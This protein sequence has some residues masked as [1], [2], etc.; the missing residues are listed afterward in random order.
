MTL[1]NIATFNI[2]Y[3]NPKDGVNAWPN[4]REWVRDLMDY[5]DFDVVGVQEALVH[6]L[7]FL[8]EK[9]L[10]FV[11]VGRDDAKRAGEFSAILYDKQRLRAVD[12]GTFWLSETPD[13]P[14]KGW[15][16]QLKR[17]CTW[18]RLQERTS[19]R[20]LYLF[21]TH[22]DHKGAVARER[23]AGVILEKIA[24][25]AGKSAPVVLTGDFNAVPDSPP[26]RRVAAVLRNARE[27]TESRPYGPHGTFQGFDTTRALEAPIDYIFVNARLRVLKFATLPDNWGQRYPSDHLPLVAKVEI[28]P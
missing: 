14:S 20:E 8:T 21:N 16:A 25:L 26:V 18:A 7:E 22:F 1:L 17:V 24:A 11:G 23:S 9:R 19:G 27:A 4:R 10:A 28:L 3:D 12:S 2:R 5:H 13:V 6:Q 15:D